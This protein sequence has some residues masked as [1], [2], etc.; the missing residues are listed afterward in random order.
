[1]GKIE[2]DARLGI[3]LKT[4]LDW[5]LQLKTM[6]D[7]SLAVKFIH[8]DYVLLSVRWKENCYDI[9]LFKGLVGSWLTPDLY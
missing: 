2:N 3:Y 9:P 1:M 7:G 4:M 6:L 8:E 5:V